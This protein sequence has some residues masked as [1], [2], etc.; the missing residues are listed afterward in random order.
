MRRSIRFI[1]IFLLTG[2]SFVHKNGMTLELVNRS[3]GPVTN[4]AFSFGG[5][6]FGVDSIAT[7]ATR[8]RWL[9]PLSPGQLNIEFDDSSGHHSA[10]P[11]TLKPTDSGKV[12][13]TFTG[14]G[15]V[16]VSDERSN[17]R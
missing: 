9:K 6:S 7:G 17:A 1:F 13:L 11:L 10:A 2:C 5:G 12:V 8:M 3:S 4:L 15:Q 14:A 16:S